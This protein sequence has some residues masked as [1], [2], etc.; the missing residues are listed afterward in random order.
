MEIKRDLYLQKLVSFM[1]DGQ[2][3]V[4]TGIRRC[5]KSYLLRTIFKNYLHE[6]GVDEEHIL[7]YELDLA[8]DIRY[9]NP[10]ELAKAEQPDLV[11]LQSRS[12]SCGAAQIYDGTFSG[13]LIPGK[14]IF[15]E[16]AV[17]AG[18]RV[19]DAEDIL[20]CGLP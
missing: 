10:L 15:A 4:I 2:V 6:Q 14:G 1:W 7:I 12:P 19:M 3:K 20:A 17:N 8:R 9:R 11:I 5:G 16:M 13:T 18:F